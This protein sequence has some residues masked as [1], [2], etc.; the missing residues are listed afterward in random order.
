MNKEPDVSVIVAAFNGAKFIAEAID[1]VLRQTFRDFEIIVVDDG[2]SDNTRQVLEPYI[3]NSSIR[4]I[5]QVNGGLAA[6]RNTGIR[7]GTG[8]YLCFLDQDDW[9]ESSSLECRLALFEEHPEL[10]FV[11]SDFRMAFMKGGACK[12]EYGESTLQKY[13]CIARIPERCVACKS[14]KYYIFNQKLFA[15]LI[16]DCFTWIATVMI[17]REVLRRVGL[18]SEEF[19]WA[20]DHDLCIRIAREYPVGFVA[21]QTAMYRQHT[22]NMSLNQGAHYEEAVRIRLN[23]LNPVYGLSN[24]DRIRVKR[25]IS[26]Y[27]CRRGHLL[28]GTHDH[29][30]AAFDICTAIQHNYLCYKC[31][32]YL[33]CSMMPVWLYS[34][35]KR[36]KQNQLRTTRATL[37]LVFIGFVSM[38]GIGNPRAHADWR[39]VWS[40]EFSG[41]SLNTNHWTYDVGNTDVWG[42]QGWGNSELEYYTPDTNN[43]YVSDGLLHIQAQIAPTNGF[44]YTSGRIKTQGLNNWTYGRFEFRARLPS[45][46]GFWP[47]IWF[48]P[49]D[50]SIYGGGPQEGGGGMY[51]WPNAGEIDLM[52][53]DGTPTYGKGALHFG[54]QN[55][56]GAS[57]EV[58][59]V[60]LDTTLFQTYMLEWT[61]GR[62][63][64]YANGVQFGT[65][66]NWWACISNTA[67]RYPYPAPFNVPFYIII[68]LAVGGSYLGNPTP[69]QI[70]PSMPGEMQIDYVRVYSEVNPGL[71]ATQTNGT[72]IVSWLEQPTSWV[73]QQ[74]TGLGNPWAQVPVAQYKTNQNQIFFTVQPPLLNNMFYRLLQQ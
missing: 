38:F 35:L 8:K 52:E 70:D 62:I 66:S 22:N 48:M 18:F 21:E 2:S 28:L 64:W 46:T 73:L 42:D 4:Y 40:D 74:T 63:N 33:F 15:E 25:S 41:S 61:N 55:P 1:S 39:L 16:L 29:F 60:S 9:L 37:L 47:A 50:P 49:S 10:G 34:E 11:F 6:A 17:P 71:S 30:K 43:V 54:G 69:A 12:I 53:N 68:N 65:T 19:R 51:D 32:K 36:W 20:P 72:I 59:S 44:R 24:K 57:D 13:D 58:G 56:Y 7:A 3:A 5:Y 23:Y 45:G 31:Y 14:N 26:D 67:S 27:C